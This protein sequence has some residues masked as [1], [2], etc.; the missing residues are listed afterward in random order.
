[1]TTIKNKATFQRLK[2]LVFGKV[3]VMSYVDLEEARAKRDVKE[4][5]QVAKDNGKRGRKCKSI[6]PEAKEGTASKVRD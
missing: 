2:S 6:T 1:M 4:S 5:T 3:K